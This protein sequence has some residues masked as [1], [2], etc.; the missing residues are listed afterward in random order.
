MIALT[1][2]ASIA[3]FEFFIQSSDTN[4]REMRMLNK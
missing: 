1:R 4:F 3:C 2:I